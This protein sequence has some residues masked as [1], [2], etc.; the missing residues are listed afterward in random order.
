M[1][2]PRPG[3]LGSSPHI[4]KNGFGKKA[5]NGRAPIQQRQA[6]DLMWSAD[7]ADVREALAFGLHQHRN[8]LIIETAP[9][10]LLP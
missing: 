3:Q 8:L 10:R 2:L 1:A 5:A 9:A 7:C 6:P 4:A